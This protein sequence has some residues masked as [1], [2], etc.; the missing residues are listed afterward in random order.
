[1]KHL[2]Q[3]SSLRFKLIGSAIIIEV[4]M[5]SFLIWNNMRLMENNLT[6][7]MTHRIQELQPL[8]N[9]SLAGPLLQGDLVTLNEI[10]QQFVKADIFYLKIYNIDNEQMMVSGTP[11]HP[12]ELQAL[13]DSPQPLTEITGNIAILRMPIQLAGQKIGH[14]L[15]EMDTAFVQNAI[16]SV[17]SQSMLIAGGEIVLSILLLGLT[18]YALTQHL[19]ALTQAAQSMA[20]GDLSVR[21]PVKTKDEI[22]VASLAFNFMAGQIS[23]DQNNLRTRENKITQLNEELEDRVKQRTAELQNANNYLQISLTQLSETQNQL[24]QS[25]K[26]ASLGGLVAGVAH[27]INTPVG[28]GVT[29]ITH[30]QMKVEE[31]T[32]RYQSGQLT[33]DD[34]ESLLKSA[35]E[36]SKIIHTNLNRAA[37][38][39]RSF[40]Q[41]AV[42]QTS[43]E[44]RSFNL[45]EY[46]H[47]ILHSLK[48]KLNTGSH[49]V[50]TNCPDEIILH[51]HP[52]A[53][54]QIVTNLVMNSIIHGF[55]D[56]LNGTIHI[57]VTTKKEGG[58]QLNYSD[59]GRGI[60]AENLQKIFE[61]FFTTR[62]GQG[63]S[64]LG[65]H[66]VYNLV[67]QTLGGEISCRNDTGQGIAFRIL[68]P[69]GEDNQNRATG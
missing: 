48:P 40:K 61:P 44:L 22:G 30:L 8:L 20:K 10:V 33:R 2:F 63:G 11:L 9:A 39:I 19:Q 32:H 53:L 37:D 1:M 49:T 42:D 15:M 57:D 21:V 18:G 25:E 13:D 60:P 65:M 47:E 28:V 52:G 26:M 45:K 3:F 64:G 14:L 43:N 23:E 46:L 36:S 38:L 29:A 6:A 4:V 66:I 54:S 34:F 27:E 17:K 12:D 7:Q 56:R 50:S 35:T 55:A 5:L 67:T 59:D 16:I 68:I 31:Y 51:S 24:V 58:I 62:R 69:A 41:V